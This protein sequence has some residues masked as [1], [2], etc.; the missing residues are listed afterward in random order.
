MSKKKQTEHNG[1]E[2]L[3]VALTKTELFIEK[4]ARWLLLAVIVIVVAVTAYLLWQS[5]YKAPKGEAAQRQS[6]YAQQWFEKDSLNLALNGDGNNLGFLDIIKEY[7][8]TKM[9]NLAHYYVGLIY[10]DQGKYEDAIKELKSYHLVDDMIAPIALGAIGDCYAQLENYNDALKY[11]EKAAS[12]ETNTLTAPIFLKKAAG[13]YE[14][15]GNWSK[16]VSAYDRIRLQY[17]N[18]QYNS[19]IGKY[20]GRAK[21]MLAQQQ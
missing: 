19:V 18:S 1:A 3:E 14:M 9:G 7:S 15:Q 16:A 20:L 13:I 6:F 12:Y 21:E 2:Q 8:G 11:Y 5:F 4:N 10:R 17:P